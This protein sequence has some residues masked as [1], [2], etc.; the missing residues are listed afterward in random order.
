MSHLQPPAESPDAHELYESERDRVG[1]VPNYAKLFGYRP[2]VYQAWAR[3]NGAIRAGMDLHRYELATLAAA[4]RLRSSYC[5][6]AHGSVLRDKFHDAATVRRIATDHRA[7][8][9]DPADVAVMD[10]ADLVATDPASVTADDVAKLRAHGLSDDEVFGVVLAVAA[11]CFFS[12]VI[13]AVGTRPDPHY[14]DSVDP[15]LRHALT[16]GRPIADPVP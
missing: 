13:E 8:G 3:L 12:T 15:G 16:V 5:S 10:F 4:R 2:E 1:F 14:R 11:R 6:L 7:A 9:L